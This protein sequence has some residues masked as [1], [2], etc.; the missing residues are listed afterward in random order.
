LILGLLEAALDHAKGGVDFVGDVGGHK[1][2]VSH[3]FGPQELGLLGLGLPQEG[4]SFGS[5][6]ALEAPQVPFAQ[7][8]DAYHDP[9]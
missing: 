9:Q 6:L 4:F 7:E 1:A 2:E 5:E 3:A 8:G